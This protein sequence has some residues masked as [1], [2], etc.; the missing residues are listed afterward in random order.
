ML[1]DLEFLVV[2][3]VM[4]KVWKK[5]RKLDRFCHQLLQTPPQ[6]EEGGGVSSQPPFSYFRLPLLQS[7]QKLDFVHCSSK[8]QPKFADRRPFLIF[9]EPA[10]ENLIQGLAGNLVLTS[11][12]SRAVFC[13]LAIC[14]IIWLFWLFFQDS[15]RWLKRRICW[16]DQKLLPATQNCE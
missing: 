15:W 11:H 16:P 2:K 9:L 4:T 10:I 5:N 8:P 13:S 6:K 1:L 12:M 7:A 14:R 3:V